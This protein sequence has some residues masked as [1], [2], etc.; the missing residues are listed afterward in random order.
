[1]IEKDDL[2]E[3]VDERVHLAA[4]GVHGDEMDGVGHGNCEDELGAREPQW[5]EGVSRG[6]LCFSRR[7]VLCVS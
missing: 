3:R 2:M 4:Y 1:V 5:Y 6:V 7:V